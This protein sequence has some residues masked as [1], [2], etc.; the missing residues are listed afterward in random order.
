MGRQIG[1][2]HEAF[3]TG[4]AHRD[5]NP[6]VTQTIRRNRDLLQIGGVR[7]AGLIIGAEISP[8]TG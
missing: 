6:G 7:R 5:Q 1:R 2:Q 3:L 8:V 4:N